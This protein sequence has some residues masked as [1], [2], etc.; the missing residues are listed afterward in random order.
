MS[1][2]HAVYNCP[3]HMQPF[4]VAGQKPRRVGYLIGMPVAIIFHDDPQLVFLLKFGPSGQSKLFLYVQLA[5]QSA[6][7]F[8]Q[9]RPTRAAVTFSFQLSQVKP[10]TR[11]STPDRQTPHTPLTTPLDPPSG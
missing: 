9:R 10:E 3:E 6:P 2:S 8:P 1:A 4:C 7:A 5:S 11:R